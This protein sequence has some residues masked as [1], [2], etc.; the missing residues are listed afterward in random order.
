M[1]FHRITHWCFVLS[2]AS[3]ALLGCAEDPNVPEPPILSAPAAPSQVAVE[4][5]SH[6]SV[7][8]TWQD[9]SDDED[10]FQLLRAE[11]GGALQPVAST[12]ADVESAVDEDLTPLAPYQYAVASYHAGGQSV[13]RLPF[14]LTLTDQF[15]EQAPA[16]PSGFSI[17][18]VSQT[19]LQLTWVDEADDEDGYRLQGG[20]DPSFNRGSYETFD[21]P[22]NT[23]SYRHEDS[24]LEPP[25]TID[26]RRRIRR[27]TPPW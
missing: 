8:V 27:G 5:I 6:T 26:S 15:E 20:P 23:T 1:P 13:S 14:S 11:D 10:G 12:G 25:T 16:A 7:R 2:F 18:V 19:V 3:L 17:S 21:L 4:Q 22:A 24:R 9:N